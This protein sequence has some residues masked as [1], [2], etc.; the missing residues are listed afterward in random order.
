MAFFNSLLGANMRLRLGPSLLIPLLLVPGL[1]LARV[2]AEAAT[3]TLGR[4]T[5]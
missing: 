3:L 5:R 4:S 1:G 2:R